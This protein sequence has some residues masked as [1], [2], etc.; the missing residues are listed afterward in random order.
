MARRAVSSAPA[1]KMRIIVQSRLSH[2]PFTV[3]QKACHCKDV[4]ALQTHPDAV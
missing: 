1:G 3:T 4:S 2:E